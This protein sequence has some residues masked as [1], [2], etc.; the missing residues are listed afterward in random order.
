M[1][2]EN[3]APKHLK[4]LHAQERF[5]HSNSSHPPKKQESKKER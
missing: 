1:R 3:F 2:K 5:N 4:I